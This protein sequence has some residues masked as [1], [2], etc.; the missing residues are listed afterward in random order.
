[1]QASIEAD[2]MLKLLSANLRQQR[3]MV[4]VKASRALLQ[5]A[6]LGRWWAESAETL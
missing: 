2:K 6:Y 1:M 4:G 5:V 3:Q